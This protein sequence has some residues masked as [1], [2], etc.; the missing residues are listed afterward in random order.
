MAR[1]SSTYGPRNLF[2]RSFHHGVD[3]STP[4][5]TPIYLNKDM[6]VTKA[7]YQKGYG[8]VIYAKDAN[9]VEHRFGH[10]D[11]IPP[12]VKPGTTIAA[13]QKLANTGNTGDSTGAHLH[14]EVRKDGKSVDP[15][16]EIDPSTGKTYD[17]SASF[18]PGGASMSGTP[19]TKDPSY[20]PG[21]PT[22]PVTPPVARQR[23]SPEPQRAPGMTPPSFPVD[24]N[25]RINPL[26]P[27]GDE[28]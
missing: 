18:T 23:Q 10:L 1:V 17:S 24:L 27:L 14:Y 25:M 6:T 7:E 13:G 28:R 8:N 3:Y 15:L 5:G 4:V 21:A 11:S 26:L 20:K 19:A 16:K 2:G 12:G 9:G 22:A